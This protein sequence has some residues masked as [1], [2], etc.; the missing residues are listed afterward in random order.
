M[1][2]CASKHSFKIFL[3]LS[4][5]L[6]FIALGVPLTESGASI[7]IVGETFSSL[8][9]KL[10][11]SS[12]RQQPKKRVKA[13]SYKENSTQAI[14]T[15]NV[16]VAS[17]IASS[18]E[19]AQLYLTLIHHAFV[20][21]LENNKHRKPRRRGSLQIRFE[22]TQAGEIISVA[23]DKSSGSNLLD[24]FTID[25]IRQMKQISPIP[26]SLSSGRASFVLPVNY[27]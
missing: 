17:E 4:F 27:L 14:A 7:S 1:E 6:N 19:Q 26:W 25:V 9:I 22:I 5:I 11:E 12:H 8:K 16:E 24:Q 13:V 23:L 2:K 18:E 3:I 20:G 15:D 21:H 10:K